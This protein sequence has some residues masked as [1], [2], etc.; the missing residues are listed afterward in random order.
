MKSSP[1]NNKLDIS[2]NSVPR[3][4][5]SYFTYRYIGIKFLNYLAQTTSD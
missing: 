3:V 2:L 1:Y 5:I 4:T